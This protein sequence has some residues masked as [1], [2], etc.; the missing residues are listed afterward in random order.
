[1]LFKNWTLSTIS[2]K[3]LWAGDP[4]SSQALSWSSSSGPCEHWPADTP[5]PICHS[6]LLTVWWI[7][8]RHSAYNTAFS[9][10]SK[11]N[12]LVTLHTWQC[13]KSKCRVINMSITVTLFCGKWNKYMLMEH[14]DKDH[15]E[16]DY[17]INEDMIRFG[18]N[19]LES[20]HRTSCCLGTVP[21]VLNDVSTPRCQSLVC[22]VTRYLANK[23]IRK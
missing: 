4:C 21:E 18:N 20:L 8:P 11:P 7:T 6:C 3:A 2:T 22:T 5:P 23:Q 14:I 12:V 13:N 16:K 19:Y 1:M 15:D 17:C 9:L 10:H